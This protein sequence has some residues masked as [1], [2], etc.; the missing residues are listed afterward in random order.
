MFLGCFEVFD[1]SHYT[2]VNRFQCGQIEQINRL[3]S[4]FEYHP[5]KLRYPVAKKYK[6]QL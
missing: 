1:D 5:L 2:F 4:Q 3:L 6:T